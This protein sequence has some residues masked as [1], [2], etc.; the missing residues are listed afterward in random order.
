MATDGNNGG[1]KI[2]QQPTRGGS[3]NLASYF[4]S[5]Y[6]VV[7]IHGS[8]A[9]CDDLDSLF[10]TLADDAELLLSTAATRHSYNLYLASRSAIFTTQHEA[11]CSAPPRRSGC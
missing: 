7:S 5:L 3:P 8:F 2:K 11:P 1:S 6:V 10:L 9:S 4:A